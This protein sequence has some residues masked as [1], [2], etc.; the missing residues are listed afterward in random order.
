MQE[1]A[2]ALRGPSAENPVE[3]AIESERLQ[4]IAETGGRARGAGPPATGRD[5]SKHGRSRARKK[6]GN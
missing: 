5:R 1:Q 6:I 2:A 4:S 3:P